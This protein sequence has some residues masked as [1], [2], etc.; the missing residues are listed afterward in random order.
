MKST[1]EFMEIVK[2]LTVEQRKRLLEY[3]RK[4]EKKVT[5]KIKPLVFPAAFSNSLIWS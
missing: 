3:A 4:L 2:R 1:E 5:K